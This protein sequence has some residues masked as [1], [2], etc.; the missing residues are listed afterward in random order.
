MPILETSDVNLMK[1]MV[2]K[3]FG[4]FHNRHNVFQGEQHPLLKYALSI[5]E[6]GHWR[7]VRDLVNPTFSITKVKAVSIG[8][9]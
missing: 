8:Y 4:T 3:D 1:K 5:T 7:H 9:S 6:D 2:I